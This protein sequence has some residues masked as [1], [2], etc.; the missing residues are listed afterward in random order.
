[1]TFVKK[2]TSFAGN[3]YTSNVSEKVAMDKVT[4][5]VVHGNR[6][7]LTTTSSFELLSSETFGKD[8]YYMLKIVKEKGQ[9][10]WK[11]QVRHLTLD[12]TEVT[13]SSK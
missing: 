2:G 13:K 5:R 6:G 11:G 10:Y 1:V 4:R 8:S 12:Y 9:S 7:T 3:S